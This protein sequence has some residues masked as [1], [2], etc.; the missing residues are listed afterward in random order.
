MHYPIALEPGDNKHA[1]D[2]F[3]PD[4]PGCFSAGDSLDDAM[5][6]ARDAILLHLEGHNHPRTQSNASTSLCPSVC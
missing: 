2:V 4:L 6:Q 5:A 3:V 1:F